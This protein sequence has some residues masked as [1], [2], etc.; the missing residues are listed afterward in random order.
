MATGKS[1]ED[2]NLKR[3]FKTGDRIRISSREA[4]PQ[5]VK[6]AVFFNHYRGLTGTIQKVY[7]GGEA[8]IEVDLDA[9]PEELWKRHMDT[10]DQM[11]EQWLRGLSDDVRRKLTPEQKQ[12]DL[13]YVALVRLQ[14]LEKPR[15][16]R[17]RKENGVS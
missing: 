4:T 3:R 15:P 17:V 8:A 2:A 6:L 16:P 12:F 9:L 14:D 7:T 11:R 13:R 10:R 5:D 1:N